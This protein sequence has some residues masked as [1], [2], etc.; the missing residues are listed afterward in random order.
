MQFIGI[1]FISWHLIVVPLFK[2]YPEHFVLVCNIV[3][4]SDK[5]ILLDIKATV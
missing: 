1:Q 4:V 2:N 3:W 5:L